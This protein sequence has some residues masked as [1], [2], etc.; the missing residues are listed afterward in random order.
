VSLMTLTTS[1]AE[2]EDSESLTLEILELETYELP[3]AIT[4]PPCGCGGGGGC[5]SCC[6]PCTD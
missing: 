1:D 3:R 6:Y 2:I 5:M 4:A